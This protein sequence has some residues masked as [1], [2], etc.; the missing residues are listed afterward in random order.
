MYGRYAHALFSVASKNIIR[1]SGR[2]TKRLS[3]NC[4]IINITPIVTSNE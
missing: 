1:E 2:K 4:F 3:G